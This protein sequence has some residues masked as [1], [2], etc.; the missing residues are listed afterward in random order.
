MASPNRS[1]ASPGTTAVAWPRS[2]DEGIAGEAAVATLLR[3][4]AGGLSEGA[5]PEDQQRIRSVLR[6]MAGFIQG[7]GV[8]DAPTDWS[9]HPLDQIP[10]FV[11]YPGCSAA[12]SVRLAV[13]ALWNDADEAVFHF[14]RGDTL[15]AESSL[16]L[17]LRE[18]QDSFSAACVR[19]VKN[20]DGDWIIKDVLEY[21]EQ[22]S[23]DPEKGDGKNTAGAAEPGLLAELG[24][25]M[26]LASQL[27]L[28]YFVQR[29]LGLEAEACETREIL[30]SAYLREEIP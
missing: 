20:E 6:S 29:V 28:F 10:Q 2:G 27:L 12:D 3:A 26:V 24:Q 18:L 11:R 1:S 30:E 5:S 16:G 9:C 25:A 4:E 22:V 8:A 19:R 13:D 15:G 7:A 17:A 21:T 14:R 23:Q